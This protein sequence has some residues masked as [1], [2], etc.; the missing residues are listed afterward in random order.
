MTGRATLNVRTATVT[1]VPQLVSLINVAFAVERAFVDRDRTDV[2]DIA[3][4][5]EK[6]VFLI[7]EGDDGD[8]DGCIY[9]ETH[10]D[11]GYIGML[12]VRPAHQGRGLGRRLMAAAEQYCRA[13]GCRVVDIKIVNLRLELPGFYRSLGYVDAGTAAFD[14]PKLTKP[15]S[16]LLMTKAL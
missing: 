11:R 1:D 15:A 5:L 9:V 6:G 2:D 12:S 14:D 10:G 16:F 13:A 3:G 4:Y 8:A 7:A